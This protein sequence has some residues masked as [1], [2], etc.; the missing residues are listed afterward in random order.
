MVIYC[1][2]DSSKNKHDYYRSKCC[3][4]K[5]CEDLRKHITKIV[6]YKKQPIFRCTEEEKQSYCMQEIYHTC[7]KEFEDCNDN[8]KYHKV[9]D[10]RHYPGKYREAAHNACNLRYKIP[11]EI[12]ILFHNGSKYDDHFIIK[13][14]AEEFEGEFECLEGN[15]KKYIIFLAS[16][17][18]EIKYT[19]REKVPSNKSPALTKS[20]SMD[21]WVAS[22]SN[23]VFIRGP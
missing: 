16:I 11:R 7:R 23:K 10:H 15:K 3:F 8:R 13:A 22:T 21:N 6:N 12:P 20:V 9:Q 18:K 14:P 4:R 1:S 19:H 17:E 2:F 5:F